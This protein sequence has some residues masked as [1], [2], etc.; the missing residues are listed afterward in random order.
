MNIVYSK[1]AIK[2][3]NSLDKPTKQRIRSAIEQLP[4]G[5]VAPMQ[6]YHDGRLRLR[7]GKYRVVFTV[8][9]DKEILYIIGIGSRGDIYK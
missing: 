9:N 3:I 5:D 7:V 8:D 2:A 6:G 4:K 1:Q